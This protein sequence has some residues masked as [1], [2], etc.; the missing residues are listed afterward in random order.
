MAPEKTQH[1]ELQ[2]TTHP[3]RASVVSLKQKSG[4][5]WR[6][7]Q[8]LLCC[9]LNVVNNSQW[10]SYA[11]VPQ[12]AADFYRTNLTV[13]NL[14]SVVYALMYL[15]GSPISASVLDGRGPRAALLIG[16]LSSFI[17]TLLRWAPTYAGPDIALG[18]AFVGQ[19][20]LGLGQPFL[21]NAP[22][23]ISAVWFDDKERALWNAIMTVGNPAGSLV[24]YAINPTFV[25]ASTDIPMLLLIW[26]IVS[27]VFFV[28]TYFL[29][30]DPVDLKTR[31]ANWEKEEGVRQSS[32]GGTLF[33]IK[34][35]LSTPPYLLILVGF[36]I[37][38]SLFNAF[39]T[40]L[41][42]FVLPFQYT[43]D[44]ASIFGAVLV[45]C[46]II[47]AGVFG[48]IVDRTLK[49]TLV[50]KIMMS[51]TFLSYLFASIVT[52]IEGL[53]P[54]LA[55][56]YALIGFCSF[57]ALPVSLELAAWFARVNTKGTL[58][59][60]RR[61]INAS[62]PSVAL[63]VE[64]VEHVGIPEGLAVGIMWM[65]AQGLGVV[66]TLAFDAARSSYG[67]KGIQGI[68]WASSASALVIAITLFFLPKEAI[69]RSSEEVTLP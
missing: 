66:F 22:T 19:V 17:G 9:F 26:F 30:R 20:I 40:L 27:A 15:F 21:L 5:F 7:T 4:K 56:A 63:A 29:A 41:T 59:R 35:L 37:A 50:M 18:L 46:G 67:T 55:A 60:M 3:N 1:L 45:L 2:S 11:P 44:D 54:A 53:M 14:L 33:K 16:A 10:V 38:V 31:L 47:S 12:Q 28:I 49:H 25:T 6:Y 69:K 58:E 23:K 39:A 48:A 52:P 61:N 42:Q 68:L 13:I 36:S 32:I 43:V 51:L 62:S 64:Q 57:A 8:A 65:A 34:V 24:A